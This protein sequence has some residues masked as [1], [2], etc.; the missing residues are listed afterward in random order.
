MHFVKQQQFET[1]K[2]WEL[3]SAYFRLY[4]HNTQSSPQVA[5]FIIGD[6]SVSEIYFWT[7]SSN[8]EHLCVVGSKLAFLPAA[9][10]VL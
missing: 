1:Q 3:E 6:V 5:V 9:A 10:A 7:E 4:S 2:N 8:P